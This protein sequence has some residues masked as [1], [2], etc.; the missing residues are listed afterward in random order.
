MRDLVCVVAL[1]LQALAPYLAWP[2]RWNIAAHMS[3]GLCITAYIVPG[4]LTNVWD[5]VSPHIVQVYAEMNLLGAVTLCVGIILGTY[6][7]QPTGL[8]R[9]LAPLLQERAEAIIHRRVITLVIVGIAGM[10]LAYAIMGFVPMFADDPLSAKQFKGAYFE[11]YRR[12]VFLFRPSL[13]IITTCMPLL[14][15]CAWKRRSRTS[16]AVAAAAVLLLALSLARGHTANGIVIFIGL[17]AAYRRDWFWAYI[18]FVALIFPLGSAGYLLLGYALG[19]ESLTNIYS[20]ESIWDIVASG[21]PDI[22]DQLTLLEGFYGTGNF[23]YGRTMIG[24]LV[25][26]NYM[27]NP[28]VWT[29]TYDNLGGDISETVSGGLRLTPALWGYAN[30]GWFGVAIIPFIS[31]VL[32]GYLIAVLRRL[33][34]QKSI[35]GATLILSL[36]M[37]LGRQ[38]VDFYGLSMYSF[39]AIA[40]LLILFL[41]PPRPRQKIRTEATEHHSP[42]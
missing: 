39:P 4:L 38:I 28:S 36:Y 13:V 33:D 11:P 5:S 8:T 30:F 34:L 19:T 31:G 1:L 2:N 17:V 23:T 16:Y 41:R 20:V 22:K 24:G 27:W 6:I 9:S 35:V 10:T 7:F 25:P 14:L 42:G 21:A 12:A 32:N 3:L 15:V 37:T 18:L 40:C 26:N 29:L